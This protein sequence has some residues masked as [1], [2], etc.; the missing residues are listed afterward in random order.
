MDPLNRYRSQVLL[1][2]RL[3]PMVAKQTCFAIKGGT[4]TNLFDRDLPRLSVDIDLV[5]LPLQDREMSLQLITNSL[6]SITD[7]A[8]QVL[9]KSR[10]IIAGPS[11][12]I[13]RYDNTHS[14]KLYPACHID[15]SAFPA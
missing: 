6:Q 3:L 1:L 13:V 2:L 11:R 12:I 7:K 9:R 8:Q 15:I 5:Y 14:G 10:C 4:A